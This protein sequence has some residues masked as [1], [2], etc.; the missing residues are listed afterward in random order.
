M[1]VYSGVVVVV[2]QQDSLEG[3]GYTRVVSSCCFLVFNKADVVVVRGLSQQVT[4][5]ASSYIVI[6]ALGQARSSSKSAQHQSGPIFLLLFIILRTTSHLSHESK[7]YTVAAYTV[8]YLG[9]LPNGRQT[10]Q[11]HSFSLLYG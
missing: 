11:T 1:R 7:T 2:V 5:K 3:T 9:L 4:E 10:T 6:Q 8:Y